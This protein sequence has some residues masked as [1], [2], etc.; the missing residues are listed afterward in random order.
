MFFCEK[1]RTFVSIEKDTRRDAAQHRR[2]A[3][4]R[5]TAVANIWNMPRK[6]KTIKSADI[7]AMA[8]RF[9]LDEME[10]VHLTFI[11]E[12]INEE[13]STIC[14]AIQHV[15]LYGSAIRDER[16]AVSALLVYFGGKLQKEND[17]RCALDRTCWEIGKNLKCGFYQLEQWYKGISIVK[18]RFGKFVECSDIY[19]LNYLE[20]E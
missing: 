7:K 3:P 2:R 8:R 6:K 15:L 13:P 11:S 12:Q 16:S 1:F 18:D 5:Q 4:G 17:M 9:Q 20:I 19:G 10:I 14:P